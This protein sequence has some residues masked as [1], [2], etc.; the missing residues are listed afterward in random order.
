M[1]E[2]SPRRRSKVSLIESGEASKRL[3]MITGYYGVLAG[4]YA[5]GL[6]AVVA[7]AFIASGPSVATLIPRPVQVVIAA[8]SFAS[9]LQT[10]RLLR[11][12]RRSGAIAAA[13]PVVFGIANQIWRDGSN[14]WLSTLGSIVGLILLATV[15]YELECL[16]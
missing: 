16:V 4:V 8:A 2:L 9:I 1:T 3:K 10:Y 13:I 6:T 15:W 11:D 14:S 12:R 7:A 5:G